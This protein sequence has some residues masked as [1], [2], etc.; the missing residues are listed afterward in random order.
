VAEPKP[1]KPQPDRGDKRKVIVKLEHQFHREL[2]AI[3]DHDRADT[4]TR[5]GKTAVLVRL[6]R[7]EHSRPTSDLPPIPSPTPPG[8]QQLTLYLDPPD[9]DRLSAIVERLTQASGYTA[10]RATAVRRLIHAEYVRL[11]TPTAKPSPRRRRPR[12]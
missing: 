3:R 8:Y 12:A 4:G 7:Q 10:N 11:T 2:S 1:R 6:I 9:L 5:L